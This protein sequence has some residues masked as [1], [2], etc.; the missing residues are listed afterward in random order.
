ML[1]ENPLKSNM[2]ETSDKIKKIAK[3]KLR[4]SVKM[5]TSLN[6]KRYSKIILNKGKVWKEHV[7]L[8]I[9]VK[10]K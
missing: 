10:I 5:A 7:N 9:T 8:F 4:P 6:N 1:K 2:V 3:F